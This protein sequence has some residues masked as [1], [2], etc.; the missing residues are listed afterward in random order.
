MVYNR[1][2]SR[3]K[4]DFVVKNE[5][6]QVFNSKIRFPKARLVSAFRII[7][8]RLFD[9]SHGNGDLWTRGVVFS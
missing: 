2:F 9:E 5:Q 1:C 8:A 7:A 3:K 4:L 6:E